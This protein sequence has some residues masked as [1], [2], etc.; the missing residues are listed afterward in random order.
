M[1]KTEAGGLRVERL[2]GDVS[3]LT[4]DGKPVARVENGAHPNMPAVRAALGALQRFYADAYDEIAAV[5]VEYGLRA[6]GAHRA[7]LSA[8][9][10]RVRRPWRG[11]VEAFMANDLPTG[12]TA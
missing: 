11:F 7:L 5:R 4:A 10:A 8:P 1:P 3:V 2:G 12:S 6:A 9:V